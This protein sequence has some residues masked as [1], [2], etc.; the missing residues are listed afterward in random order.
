[1]ITSFERR[2]LFNKCF[3]TYPS[4]RH[5]KQNKLQFLALKYYYKTGLSDLKVNTHYPPVEKHWFKG[6]KKKFIHLKP[7]HL[8][9]KLRTFKSKQKSR[10][11]RMKYYFMSEQYPYI[12]ILNH[13]AH[14]IW[15]RI[16]KMYV[17]KVVYDIAINWYQL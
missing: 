5:T 7:S 8:I 14:N 6:S 12:K 1:M 2:A 11:N 3:S 13:P 17:W 4:W 10:C 16:I 9:F 15:I